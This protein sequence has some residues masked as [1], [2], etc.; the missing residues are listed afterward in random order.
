MVTSAGNS[1]SATEWSYRPRSNRLTVAAIAVVAT[2]I[3]WSAWEVGGTPSLLR[4]LPWLAA[5]GVLTWA[6]YW[7]TEV[8]IEEEGPVLVNPVRTVAVPWAALVEVRTRYA[9]TLVTPHGAY[10][11]WAAPGPGRHAAA[12]ATAV[13]LRA[14]PRSGFDTRGSVAIGDLP[15]SPSGVAAAELRRRWSELAEAEA[16]PLGEADTTPVVVRWDRWTILLIVAL[17][18]L[19]ALALVL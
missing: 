5:V 17:L 16:I 9:L 8:R 4:A 13:D 2:G 19:G 3:G 14:V 12:S 18:A 15:R 7:R 6:A 11:A 10:R 1:T